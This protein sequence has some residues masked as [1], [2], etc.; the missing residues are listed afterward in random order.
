MANNTQKFVLV[1]NNTTDEELLGKFLYYSLAD[2]LVEKPEFERI[3]MAMNFP[4]IDRQ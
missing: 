1:R 2:I 3:S 4:Y